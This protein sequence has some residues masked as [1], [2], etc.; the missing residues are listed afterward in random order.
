M[1]AR[2]W[3][4]CIFI[5]F[6][7]FGLTF[8][9]VCVSYSQGDDYLNLFF[10]NYY[11]TWLF[12]P[13]DIQ[14]SVYSDSSLYSMSRDDTL[15]RGRTMSDFNMFYAQTGTFMPQSIHYG[16]MIYGYNGMSSGVQDYNLFL[17]ND[18]LSTDIIFN[19]ISGNY[20]SLVNPV[21]MFN[22]YYNYLPDGAQNPR[23]SIQKCLYERKD[24]DTTK[25]IL[26]HRDPTLSVSS[27]DSLGYTFPTQLSG[28][29][30]VNYLSLYFICFE[31]S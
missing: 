19:Q 17:T 10:Q 12:V 4:L 20:Q 15:T 13:S 29:P 14:T 31:G 22:Q 23:L 5:I 27:G 11:S 9:A 16:G 2:N 1:R 26:F 30:S 3:K 6:L 7:T 25:C 21:G 24:L 28:I 8:S 18:P